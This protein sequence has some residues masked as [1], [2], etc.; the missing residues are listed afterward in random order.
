MD[1]Y[2]QWYVP[3]RTSLLTFWILG[4][5]LCGVSAFYLNWKFGAVWSAFTILAFIVGENQ[6]LRRADQAA[7][8]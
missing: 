3:R 6:L 5:L 2:S 8:R 7:S 4:N 1:S